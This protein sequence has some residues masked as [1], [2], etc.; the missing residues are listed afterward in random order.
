[1]RGLY[2]RACDAGIAFVT[3]GRNKEQGSFKAKEVN[4]NNCQRTNVFKQAL[5]V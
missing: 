3:R 5:K 1:M 4:C 2:Y